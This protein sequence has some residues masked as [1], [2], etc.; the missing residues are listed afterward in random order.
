M[1]YEDER[2]WLKTKYRSAP[3]DCPLAK[4]VKVSSIKSAIESQFARRY[5]HKTLASLIHESFPNTESTCSSQDRATRVFGLEVEPLAATPTPTVVLD[6]E[7]AELEART[8]ELEQ[9]VKDL[10][11]RVSKLEEQLQATS[12]STT[13]LMM[14]VDQ[15][16]HHNMSVYH[17]PSTIS[18]FSEFSLEKI[19]S[20]IEESAPALFQLLKTLSS[21]CDSSATSDPLQSSSD[22]QNDIKVITSLSVHLRSRSAKV[23]GIQ[24]L[25]G[26]MLVGRGTGRGVRDIQHIVH[27]FSA[28]VQS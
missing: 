14:Q 28:S 27:H 5:E 18:H 6:D 8:R 13:S 3:S 12:I 9:T 7:K 22:D 15:L 26:M 20:E 24:L 1:E 4:R 19:R 11:V 17:G 25:I 23:L 16:L 21:Q 10:R 2:S